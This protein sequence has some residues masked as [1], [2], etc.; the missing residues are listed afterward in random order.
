MCAYFLAIA[1][2]SERETGLINTQVLIMQQNVFDKGKLKAIIIAV[3]H[4][5]TFFA[6]LWA[7]K[8]AFLPTNIQTVDKKY[9]EKSNQERFIDGF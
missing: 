5:F 6:D 4:P 3:Y 1:Q 7:D 8:R 9:Y 2:N